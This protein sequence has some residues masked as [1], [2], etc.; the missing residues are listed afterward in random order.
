[1]AVRRPISVKRCAASA[2][3]ESSAPVKRQGIGR[4]PP[5]TPHALTA[6]QMICSPPRQRLSG[7]SRRKSERNQSIGLDGPTVS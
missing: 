5:A 7:L 3:A 2:D 1:M 4:T 6:T